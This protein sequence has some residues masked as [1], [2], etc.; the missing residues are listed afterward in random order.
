M[1]KSEALQLL[2][3]LENNEKKLPLKL[4]YGNIQS[5]DPEKFW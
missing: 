2:N 4:I 5:R 1:T 3:S